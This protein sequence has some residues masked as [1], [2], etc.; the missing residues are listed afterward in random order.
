MMQRFYPARGAWKDNC[1]VVRGEHKE[2][3][4]HSSLAHWSERQ[5][6]Y[7]YL[8]HIYS[9]TKAILHQCYKQKKDY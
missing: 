6:R 1:G 7:L 8:H 2:T 3:L 4:L 5:P 9:I